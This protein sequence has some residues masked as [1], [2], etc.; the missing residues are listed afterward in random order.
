MPDRGASYLARALAARGGRWGNHGYEAAYAFAYTDADGDRLDGRGRY[1]LTFDT[2]PPAGAFWSVTMY[3]LPD[4]YLVANPIGRYSIGD[5]TPGLRRVAG[6]PLTI[7]IQ[8]ERPPDASNWLP[9][10]AAPFRPILRLY[11]PRASVLDGS[12]RIPPI[13]KAGRQSPSASYS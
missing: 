2:E 6:E 9:A 5:R 13:R 7:E 10:P 12:Y 1:T 3:D 8:H 4:Y 11:Q